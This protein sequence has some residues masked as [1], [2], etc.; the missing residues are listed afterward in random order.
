[1]QRLAQAEGAW[2]SA[3]LATIGLAKGTH[4][5]GE[6]GH[7]VD[8]S[9]RWLPWPALKVEAGYSLLALGDGARAILSER[10]LMAP[11]L[12]HLGYAQAT[13]LVP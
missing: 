4:S 3:Y 8:A 10:Q 2:V 6:L 11:T 7:E 13:V 12:S 9:L 1:M 5:S